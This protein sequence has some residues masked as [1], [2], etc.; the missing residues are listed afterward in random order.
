M[1]QIPKGN[2]IQVREKSKLD[3]FLQAQAAQVVNRLV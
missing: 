1:K 2:D 3:K